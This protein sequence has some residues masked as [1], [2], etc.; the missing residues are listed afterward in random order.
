MQID[1]LKLKEEIKKVGAEIMK[2]YEKDFE[3]KDK[4]DS[5]PVTKADLLSNKLL[6][7]ILEKTNIPILSEEIKDNPER[8]SSDKLWIIDPLDGTKDFIQKTDEFSIMVALVEKGEPVLGIVYAPALG[9]IYY[10]EKNKGAY[11]EELKIKNEK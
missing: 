11:V 9:K 6:V 5:S 2:L 7:E 8:L 10:A 1:I 3:I 4:A